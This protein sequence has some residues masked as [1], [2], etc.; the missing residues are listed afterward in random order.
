MSNLVFILSSLLITAILTIL[1]MPWGIRLFIKLGLGKNIRSEGLIGAATEFAGLHAGKKGTPTMGGVIIIGIILLVVFLS[2]I[3]QYFGTGL[4]DIFGVSFR[5]SLWNR[6]ETYIVIFTLVSVGL[7]GLVDDYLNIREI[8]RTK[9]LSAK[10]KML[11]LIIFAFI[12]AY[13]FYDKLGY[14]G[15]NLPFYGHAELGILY[16]PL[17]ILIFIATANSVNITD[18]LDGLAGGLLLFQFLAYGAITYMQG[19]FILSAFCLIIVGVL[20]GFLWFNIHPAQIFMGDTGS[21]ALGATLAVIAMMTDTLLAFIVMSSIFIGETLSV[22][23]QMTSKKFRNGK[24]IFRI[25]PFHHHLEAIGW[26]EETIVMRLW[27]LGMILTIAGT[28]MAL[29]G[30]L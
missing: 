28:I 18:G 9:G 10:V 8:G 5:Y 29:I 21:L 17:F 1:I 15:I 19:M 13:W 22:I 24:K 23:V 3:A 27:L 12:G 6:G 25:A 7:I 11:L 2:V 20:M 16:I 4:S 14:T 26:D 30:N